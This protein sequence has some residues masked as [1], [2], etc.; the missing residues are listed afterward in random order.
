MK[1]TK[2]RLKEI[3]KEE[4][5]SVLEVRDIEYNQRKALDILADLATSNVS[6]SHLPAYHHADETTKALVSAAL[7]DFEERRSLERLP[8]PNRRFLDSY[9]PTS[10]DLD[11]TLSD[12]LPDRV[13]KLGLPW[14]WKYAPVSIVFPQEAEYASRYPDPFVPD[15]PDYEGEL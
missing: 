12:I 11:K 4:L 5:S 1:L 6:V 13:E 9:R 2:Q 10:D 8:E 15:S 3:I 14:Y 7:K